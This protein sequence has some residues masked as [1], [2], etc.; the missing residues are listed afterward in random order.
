M[1]KILA[2]SVSCLAGCSTGIVSADHDSYFVSVKSLPV[3]GW[4]D[5]AAQEKARVY[6]EANAY[7]NRLGGDVDTIALDTHEPNFWRSAQ[8]SLQFRCQKKS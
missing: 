6:A 7:C 5:T 8:A 1:K 2:L 4:F 3:H